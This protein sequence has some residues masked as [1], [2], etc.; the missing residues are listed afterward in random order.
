MFAVKSSSAMAL[1]LLLA[2]YTDFTLAACPQGPC[3]SDGT[4][5][6]CACKFIFINSNWMDDACS[7]EMNRGGWAR[8]FLIKKNTR[9]IRKRGLNFSKQQFNY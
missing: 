4:Q 9:R 1:I 6:W 5:Q 8:P 2:F 3:P 7:K